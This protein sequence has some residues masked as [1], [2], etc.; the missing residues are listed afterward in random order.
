M[1]KPIPLAHR[2]VLGYANCH[3]LST[4]QD[5]SVNGL[6]LSTLPLYHGFGALAPCLSLSVGK[7]VLFPPAS[8][9]PSASLVTRLVEQYDI[10]WLMTVP[11]ILEELTCLPEF[12]SAVAVFTRLEMVIV[13]GG[14]L[15][16]SVG[17]LLDAKGVTILN[18]FGATELGALAPIF[19]PEP[20]Y[21]FRFLKIRT[22]LGLRLEFTD[23]EGAQENAGEGRQCKLLGIP[24]GWQEPFELQD[25]LICNHLKPTREVKILGRADDLI[26]LATGEKVHPFKVEKPLEQVA[27]IKRAV[28]FGNGREEIGVLVELDTSVSQ[29]NYDAADWLWPRVSEV[30]QILDGHAKISSKDAIIIKPEDKHFVLTDKG[31]ISRKETYSIFESEINAAYKKL[32]DGGDLD[33]LT[34]HCE[35]DDP[36]SRLRQMVQ[37]CL[38]FHVQ[39]AGWSDDDDFIYLG[40]DS[41]QASR[42]RRII[43]ASLE[44][45]DHYVAKSQKLSSD[46]VYS[47][48]SVSKLA[49]ALSHPER[50][51]S[52]DTAAIMR[53]LAYKYHIPTT[54][55]FKSDKPE[56][57][58]GSSK[59]VIL[60]SGSTGTLGTH[61]LCSLSANPRVEEIICLVRPAS[62]SK[63]MDPTQELKDRQHKALVTRGLALPEAAWAKISLVPWNAGADKLG[64][65][66]I[67]YDKIVHNVTHIF[68]G[69]WPM[70]FQRKLSSF[71]PMI[72]AVRDFIDLGLAIRKAAPDRSPPRLLVASSIAV[73]GRWPQKGLGSVVSEEI[74]QDTTS[75]LPMGYAEAKWICEQIA[76]SAYENLGSDLNLAIVRIG[77]VSGA[78]LTGF[79]SPNE[80][81]PLLFKMAKKRGAMPDL[82]GVSPSP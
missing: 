22:D 66:Q 64:L 42:L 17:E 37:H 30:N 39:K 62:P 15:K 74:I 8:A 44:K 70:D 20:D 2:Y 9:I 65:D 1:P 51:T 57:A 61:L 69:A 73:V 27:G 13:G 47:N 11:S 10:A 12:D 80:H 55:R 26:V 48:P 60:L 29:L 32:Q 3:E 34:I 6:N 71:E 78:R 82:Q 31:S 56:S 75:P 49:L 72:K 5:E 7:P 23:G 63:T 45:S 19:R 36:R 14:G 58:I 38:P 24:F 21:D 59:A 68:H 35:G 43:S 40:M 77:Q 54:Q 16:P 28:A 25:I 41:L 18:H 33:G 46:F 67:V 81:L 52:T 50:T 4:D 76:Q 53:Q 79:W